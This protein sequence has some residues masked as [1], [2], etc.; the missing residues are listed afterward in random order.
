MSTVFNPMLDLK[1]E[2]VVDL[3]PAELWAAWTTPESIRHWFCPKPWLTTDC[4]IDLRLGGAFASTLQ[5]PEGQIFLNIGC[6][7]EIIPHNKLVWTNSLAPDFRPRQT[8]TTANPCDFSMT[9]ILEFIPHERGTKYRA[10][11]LHATEKDRETHA[12]MGFAKGWGVVL[13]Q[14]VAH[15]KALR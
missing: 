1:L 14:M 5:S 2:R 15:V 7:L 13:D 12:G 6:Y 4:T 10:I 9:V 11:V 8:D 3:T